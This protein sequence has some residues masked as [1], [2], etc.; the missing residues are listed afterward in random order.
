M[1]RTSRPFRN[2]FLAGL[3]WPPLMV[4]AVAALVYRLTGMVPFP[5]GRT[6]EG[7]LTVQLVAPERVPRYWRLW[8]D[9]LEPL[10][11]RIAE[12]IAH[13]RTARQGAWLEGR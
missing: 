11:A 5:T 12:V 8:R 2:G 4:A 10:I 6:E 1:S 3:F 13:V 9:E 7:C